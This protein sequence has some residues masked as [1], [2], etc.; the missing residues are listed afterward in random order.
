M[1]WSLEMKRRCD[2]DNDDQ[3][4][5]SISPRP[6]QKD[7]LNQFIVHSALDCVDQLIWSGSDMYL[8]NVDR[9]NELIISAFVTASRT[10]LALMTS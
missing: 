3:K 9:F 2:D 8:R 5:K 4:E 7:D 10:I 6:A 1:I